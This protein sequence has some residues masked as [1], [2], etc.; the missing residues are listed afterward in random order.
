[1]PWPTQWQVPVQWPFWMRWAFHQAQGS[2]S[3]RSVSASSEIYAPPPPPS[4]QDLLLNAEL[5]TTPEELAPCYPLSEEGK[6]H[7]P[8]PVRASSSSL[9]DEVITGTSSAP[10]LED[11]SV[12]QQLLKRV[13]QNLGLEVEEVAESS[14]P[15]VDILAPSGPSQIALPLIKTTQDTIKLLWQTSA[16]LPPIVKRTERKYFVLSKGFEHFDS[17]PPPGS[18]V[19]AVANEHK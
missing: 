12:H 3:R 2:Y 8:V 9:P 10:V 15:M 1:M 17:H 19:V 7:K 5:V 11:S 4:V 18:L 16:S 6:E 13:A 14:D